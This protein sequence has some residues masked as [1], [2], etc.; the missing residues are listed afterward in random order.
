[1]REK[2]RDMGRG[3]KRDSARVKQSFNNRHIFLKDI[4]KHCF[5]CNEKA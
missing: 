1:M 5:L 2:E 3:K 4:G